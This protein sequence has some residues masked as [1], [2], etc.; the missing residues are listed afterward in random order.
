[1]AAWSAKEIARIKA[2]IPEHFQPP[3]E[4]DGRLSN[5]FF[6]VDP[7]R[8]SDALHAREL[9]RHN[10]G[11]A[12][13]DNPDLAG[14]NVILSGSHASA[15][16]QRITREERK[17]READQREVIEQIIAQIE[18]RNREIAENLAR[19][20]ELD[21]Q[22][23]AL[24]DQIARLQRGEELERD[25]DGHL[26]DKNA[27]D[28]IRE[29]EERYG[30]KVDRTDAAQLAIILR[31]VRDEQQKVRRDNETLIEANER[32][33][34][35]AIRMGADP[36][37]IPATVTKLEQS[38]EGQRSIDKATAEMADDIER[39]KIADMIADNLADD[40]LTGQSVT[41]TD[42]VLS[43]DASDIATSSD[44]A[45]LKLPTPS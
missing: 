38:A 7:L 21:A 2:R 45:K 17:K 36:A 12:A 23:A 33:R 9:E 8:E 28:A 41:A 5:A 43:E 30:V 14:S 1:M 15:K 4:A 44:V 10:L 13:L 6:S 20:E 24:N 18:A 25:A 35:L 26:K 11:M 31:G 3:H 32:D 37:S 40:D 42:E 34:Q 16:T 39:L 29:Y 27:E 19:L 22:E